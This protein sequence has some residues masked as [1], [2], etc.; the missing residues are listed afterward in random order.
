M[1]SRLAACC[2]VQTSCA[3]IASVHIPTILIKFT[4]SV[5]LLRF[6]LFWIIIRFPKRI[7]LIAKFALFLRPVFT[8]K[9]MPYSKRYAP[10]KFYDTGIQAKG[11]GNE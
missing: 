2:V 9:S 3:K 5:K 7:V 10:G 11:R 8:F 1:P 4:K 6:Q